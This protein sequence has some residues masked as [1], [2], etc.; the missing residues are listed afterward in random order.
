MP[1]ISLYIDRDLYKEVKSAAEKKD[2]SL[3]SFVSEVLKEHLVDEWPEGYFDLIGSLK[4]DPLELPEDLS[5]ELDSPREV[6]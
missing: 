1:Q 2:M 4:D 3:S 6:L 5:W